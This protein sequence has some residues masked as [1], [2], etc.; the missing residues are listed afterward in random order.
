MA[1]F[2]IWDPEDGEEADGETIEC[3]YSQPITV[4]KD[5]AAH[6]CSR[7]PEDYG[8][9][10]DGGRDV[11]VRDEAGGLHRLAVSPMRIWSSRCLQTRRALR[12]RVRRMWTRP[13]SS[14]GRGLPILSGAAL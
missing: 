12:H 13:E 6:R 5:F 9:Y 10:E 2:T 11:N 1:K 14:D 3:N 7:D 8:L 4:A